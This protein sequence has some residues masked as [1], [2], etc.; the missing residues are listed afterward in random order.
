MYLIIAGG[1]KVGTNLTRSLLRGGHMVVRGQGALGVAKTGDEGLRPGRQQGDAGGLDGGRV[2]GHI[3][4]RTGKD[5]GDV[6]A[7]DGVGGGTADLG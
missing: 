2:E 3:A 4:L 5:L 7:D 1:G 6:H